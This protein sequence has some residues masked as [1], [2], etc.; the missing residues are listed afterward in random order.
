MPHIFILFKEILNID[1]GTIPVYTCEKSCNKPCVEEYAF[2][3]RTGEKIPE[4]EPDDQKQVVK[5][6]IS[7][8]EFVKNLN[9]L[10]VR[11]NIDN[12]PDEDGFIE[13]KKKNKK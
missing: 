5:K 11:G 12:T 8:E 3:Q 9:K 4:L 1:I 6:D 13:V 2:I 10:T 7:D